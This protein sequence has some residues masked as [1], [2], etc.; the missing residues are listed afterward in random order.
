[1][2]CQQWRCSV[3]RAVHIP[4]T[5]TVHPAHLAAL[6]C[7]GPN[8]TSH[9]RFVQPARGGVLRRC[10]QRR[11]GCCQQRSLTRRSSSSSSR[12]IRRKPVRSGRPAVLYTYHSRSFCN[13]DD[14]C[15]RLRGWLGRPGRAA[16]RVGRALYLRPL[17]QRL[18]TQH[19][20]AG[21]PL[22]AAAA[23]MACLGLF[24][25]EWGRGRAPPAPT[26]R[27]SR[28]RRIRPI[29]MGTLYVTCVRCGTTTLRPVHGGAS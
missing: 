27:P 8:H 15:V 13:V 17:G 20:P 1:M 29:V 11:C 10:T 22:Q 6:S 9:T 18:P 14:A 21:E 4:H 26:P 28:R 16:S 24:R 3:F 2:P 25:G 23:R 12:Y 7:S 19:V 5:L